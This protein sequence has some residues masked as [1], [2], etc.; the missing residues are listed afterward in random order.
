LMTLAGSR[1]TSEIIMKV[2]NIET[3]ISLRMTIAKTM[4]T[5][6][7]FLLVL[8]AIAVGSVTATYD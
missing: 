5:K 6:H 8:A 3:C 7:L 2:M 4:I 1:I